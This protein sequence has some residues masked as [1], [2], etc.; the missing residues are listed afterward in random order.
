MDSVLHA[1]ES[2]DFTGL[3]KSVGDVIGETVDSI[4]RGM[5]QVGKEIE[6]QAKARGM[7]TAGAAQ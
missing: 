1:V 7:D 5:N 4:G 3:S 6:R 2:G